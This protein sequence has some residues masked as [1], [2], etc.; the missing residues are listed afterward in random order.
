MKFLPT[1]RVRHPAT[2]AFVLKVADMVRRGD[3]DLVVDSLK[4][5]WRDKKAYPWHRI[6]N[7]LARKG[8]KTLSEKEITE[9]I[10]L[11]RDGLFASLDMLS[12]NVP[13]NITTRELL[14]IVLKDS[15]WKA[16]RRAARNHCATLVK[17]MIDAGKT[18]LFALTGLE[19]DGFRY[20]V[21]DIMRKR[22]EIFEAARPEIKDDAYDLKPLRKCLLG[23]LLLRQLDITA[24][25]LAKDDPRAEEL[26]TLHS[27]ILLDM[28]LEESSY[29][30]DPEATAQV[31]LNGE[32]IDEAEEPEEPTETKAHSEESDVQVPLTEYI[33]KD[34]A[35]PP[36][37]PKKSK[38]TRSKE[39]STKGTRKGTKKKST[40]K[41]PPK[42]RRST[43]KSKTK[44]K[45]AS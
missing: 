45:E 8:P 24:T 23:C 33:A 16:G 42:K 39:G 19:H 27:H 32:I 5:Y 21:P 14:D 22:L 40:K 44:E 26:L 3:M 6:L 1:R 13:L 18:E 10:G 25:K 11:L 9:C 17:E 20:L 36:K 30:I 34:K 38:T 37:R 31:T 15:S 4:G 43:K 29:V 2:I 35:A 41:R 12:L 28:E 7:D